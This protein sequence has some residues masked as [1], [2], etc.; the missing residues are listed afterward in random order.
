MGVMGQN[1][2]PCI[3]MEKHQGVQIFDTDAKISPKYILN[4]VSLY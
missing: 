4:I 2:V 1:I 3:E